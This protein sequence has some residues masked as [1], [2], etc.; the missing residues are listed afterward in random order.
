[1]GFACGNDNLCIIIKLNY[2]L[3]C[4]DSLFDINLNF[5]ETNIDK[6]TT[7]IYIILTQF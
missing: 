4:I 3:N 5:L 6:I 1:M 2:I 7:L